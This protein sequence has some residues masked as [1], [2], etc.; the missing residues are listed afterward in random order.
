[1]ATA[2][3]TKGLLEQAGYKV[4]KDPGDIRDLVIEFFY[5]IW[6]NFDF[7]FWHEIV[8]ISWK[9]NFYVAYLLKTTIIFD[10]TEFEINKS[11]FK[12]NIF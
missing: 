11:L 2:E 5:A 7:L 12:K 10:H 6:K 9:L 1:M 4:P 3:V 8:T